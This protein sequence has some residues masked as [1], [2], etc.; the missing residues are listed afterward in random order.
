LL[1]IIPILWLT[2][3]RTES[4]LRRLLEQVEKAAG[5]LQSNRGEIPPQLPPR[6][7]PPPLPPRD[8]C[9]QS[10]P[11]PPRDREEVKPLTVDE[12][13]PDRPFFALKLPPM[14]EEEIPRIVPMEKALYADQL[15]K[16]MSQMPVGSVFVY[17]EK[18]GELIVFVRDRS[19]VAVNT[20][21]D[22]EQGR[23]FV[24][25]YIREHHLTPIDLS[26]APLPS[27]SLKEVKAQ[28]ELGLMQKPAG[29]VFLALDS[30][31]NRIWIAIRSKHQ[32]EWLSAENTARDFANAH[33]FIQANKLTP[34]SYDDLV[35]SCNQL[36]TK[37]EK[38]IARKSNTAPQGGFAMELQRGRAGLN[39]IERKDKTD[40]A[41]SPPENLR[42]LFNMDFPKGTMLTV[43]VD[44]EDEVGDEW[45]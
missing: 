38:G 28:V 20:I 12:A 41:V 14:S 42:G 40:A 24:Q 15:A 8:I 6:E 35:S 34:I 23:E 2:H 29:T 7:S 3:G 30:G 17:P 19:G 11:L 4:E 31:S 39:H 27:V 32:I 43:S 21:D 13:K 36:L 9:H 10:P 44:G 26:L 25:N 5:A 45:L 18:N 33:Q 16:K 37:I 22:T 1:A